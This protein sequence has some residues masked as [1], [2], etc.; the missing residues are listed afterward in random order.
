MSSIVLANHQT[1]H[2][3]R[4]LDILLRSLFYVDLSVMGTGKTYVTSKILQHYGFTSCIV[5][6]PKSA[7][8]VW[9]DIIQS[10][11]LPVVMV[12]SYQSLSS[13]SGKQPKHGYLRRIDEDGKTS[14]IASQAYLNLIKNGTLLILDEF[15]EVK[16]N[17]SNIYKACKALVHPFIVSTELK[18]RLVLLSA[19]PF[20][21][22]DHPISMM[23]MVGI[24]RDYRLY[25]Y[26]NDTHHLELLG[27]QQVVDYCMKLDRPTTMKVLSE[28]P[29]TAKTVKHICYLL[30]I[31]I[32]QKHV[33][34]SMPRPPLPF[35]PIIYNGF[36]KMLPVD[37]AAYIAAVNALHKATA[38][39]QKD[40]QVNLKNADMGAIKKAEVAIDKSRVHTAVRLAREKLIKYPNCKVIIS[41]NYKG[42]LATIANNLKEYNPIIFEGKTQQKQRGALIKEFQAHDLN[43]RLFISTLRT[44]ATG[45]S[46]DD[47][48]EGGRFPRF[49]FAFPSYM[50]MNIQQWTGRFLRMN[51][52]SQPTIVFIYGNTMKG[53]I[54][55]DILT[56]MVNREKSVDGAM[57]RT[58]LVFEQTLEKQVEDGVIFPNRYPQ[59]LEKDEVIVDFPYIRPIVTEQTIN[60]EVKEALQ[61]IKIKNGAVVVKDDEDDDTDD[62]TDVVVI[63]NQVNNLNINNNNNINTNYL[64]TSERLLAVP[65]VFKK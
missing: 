59:V 44:G 30:Y 45:I 46:L 3:G 53:N 35:K 57:K 13:V 24:I 6:C 11:N 56:S 17:T 14:F 63:T 5:V 26:H 38:F 7:V 15:Q 1:E 22:E 40:N 18:S 55:A 9:T 41:V 21:K 48:S 2:F 8:S 33:C 39:S 27:A 12:S 43:R 58:G 62:D 47:T 28:N 4:L 51:T 50:V 52:K 49:A 19:T 34:S 29:W 65:P 32:I 64:Q 54:E 61:D 36:F 37:E 20:S 60:N 25:V 10:Y 23:Q 16:N 31:N 42:D